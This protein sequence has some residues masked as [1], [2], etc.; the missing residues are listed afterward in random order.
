MEAKVGAEDFDPLE[1]VVEVVVATGDSFES[2]CFLKS[3]NEF[4]TSPSNAAI[5]RRQFLSAEM[6]LGRCF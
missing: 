1:M 4:V 2:R 5:C 6:R 3:L